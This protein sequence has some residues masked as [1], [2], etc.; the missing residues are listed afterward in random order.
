M[1]FHYYCPTVRNNNIFKW[2]ETKW[3]EKKS[4]E[5]GLRTNRLYSVL[6]TNEHTAERGMLL[7]YVG[8]AFSAQYFVFWFIVD[9]VRFFFPF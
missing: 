7:A 9:S 1:R 2:N 4:I 5:T 3:K 8:T 6:H